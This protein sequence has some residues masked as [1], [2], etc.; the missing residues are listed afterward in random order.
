MQFALIEPYLESW[1]CYSLAP[2]SVDLLRCAAL[3]LESAA[4]P[5]R[6]GGWRSRCRR[7]SPTSDVL[8]HPKAPPRRTPMREEAVASVIARSE[9]FVT[10]A[11]FGSAGESDTVERPRTPSVV[12]NFR[13]LRARMACFG[14]FL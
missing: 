2:A 5:S 3:F 6:L 8:L 11:A 13:L 7:Y 14:A 12:S 1:R 9:T 4:D 10:E